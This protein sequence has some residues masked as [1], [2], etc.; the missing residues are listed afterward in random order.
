MSLKYFYDNEAEREELKAFMI[1]CLEAMTIE[2]VFN[3]KSING[4]MDA[5][6]LIDTMFN[7]L[8]EIYG[9]QKIPISNNP[10]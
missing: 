6:E 8:E 2:R 4:I 1:E 9:E 5:R 7:K 3:N 10:R